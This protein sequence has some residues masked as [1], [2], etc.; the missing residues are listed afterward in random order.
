VGRH[1]GDAADDGNHRHNRM[2]GLFKKKQQ[3]KK[4]KLELFTSKTDARRRI[5]RFGWSDVMVR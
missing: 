2:P 3:Q 1:R 5:N 4:Q